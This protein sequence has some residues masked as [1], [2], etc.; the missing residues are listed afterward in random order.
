[1]STVRGVVTLP[2]GDGL[3]LASVKLRYSAL[4]RIAKSLYRIP[5]IEMNLLTSDSLRFSYRVIPGLIGDE[6]ILNGLPYTSHDLTLLMSENMVT[7][8]TVSFQLSGDGLNGFEDSMKVEF[9]RVDGDKVTNENLPAPAQLTQKTSPTLWSIDMI[10][11]SIV[12]TQTGGVHIKQEPAE[13]IVI[14]GWAVDLDAESLAAGIWVNID[15]RSYPALYH[16]NR[17]DVANGYKMKEYNWC[18]FTAWIPSEKLSF[19]DEHVVTLSIVSNDGRS[20]YSTGLE[21]AKHIR[22]QH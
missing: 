5:E 9:R 18:G 19:G 10:D 1:M 12:A 8:R 20:Y 16:L 13:P 15:G 3:A 4:G 2:D 17:P 21:K 7:H 14:R 11:D 22:L 6:F